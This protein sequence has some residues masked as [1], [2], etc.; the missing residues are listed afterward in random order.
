[1]CPPVAVRT[2][3]STCSRVTPHF[4]RDSSQTLWK[5]SKDRLRVAGEARPW[6]LPVEG[7][8]RPQGCG[9]R[10]SVAQWLR[11]GRSEAAG[12]RVGWPASVAGNGTPA[13]PGEVLLGHKVPAELEPSRPSG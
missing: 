10:E 3:D 12:L 13:P 9:W 2:G 11:V 7:E 1:M 4:P 5:V 8:A 6:W